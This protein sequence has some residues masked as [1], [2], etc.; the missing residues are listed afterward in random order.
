MAD[1]DAKRITL[2]WLV[3]GAVLF[4]GLALAGLVIR[5]AQTWPGLISDRAFYAT[6]TLHGSG[7]AGISLTSIM[8]VFWYVMRQVLPLSVAA[9]KAAYAL[10]VVGALLMVVAAL[11]GFGAGWTMLYPLPSTPGP[12]PGWQSWAA[13]AYI[14]GIALVNAAFA[15]WSLDFLRAGIA[16]YGGLGF[17]LGLDV[18]GGTAAHGRERTTPSVIAGT[19][20]AID[21]IT[22][23]VPG[24]VGITLM[25]IN[26]FNPSFTVNPLLAKNLN[27]FA[28]HVLV[29]VPI[30][31]GAGLAYAL[32]PQYTHR[33]WN[34]SRVLV[35]GW[36]VTLMLVMLAAFHHLYQDFAQ[37]TIAQV[38]GTIASYASAFPPIVVTIFGALMLVYRSEMRWSVAPLFLYTALAGWAI[39]GYAAVIDSNPALN[40]Y[41]HNTLWTPAYFHTLMALAVSFFMLGS[42]YHVLPELT[43]RRLA[44]ALGKKA[45]LLLIFGGWG[46]VMMWFLAG[47]LG[48]PRRY[49]FYLANLT[50]ITWLATGFAL[51]AVLG[52]LVIFADFVRVVFGYARSD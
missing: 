23:I 30:Y 12:V 35:V 10:T 17:M 13:A 4:L 11:G 45:A 39:G 50:S 9:L 8:V 31:L 22:A 25:L 52:V 49:P 26:V 24:T 18:L 29:N 51:I 19:V 1:V 14:I 44:E 40:Q 38:I 34:V 43:G 16:R 28:G 42:V 46:L 6:M 5:F 48:Q 47:V 32:L 21:G 36:L 20:V 37:P 2:I 41:L 27:F 3:T 7:M 15:L 33:A